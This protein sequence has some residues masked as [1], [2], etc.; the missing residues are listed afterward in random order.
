[1][2]SI[3]HTM[4]SR[5]S[6]FVAAMSDL[7][8]KSGATTAKVEQSLGTF[9][10]VTA[11][12]L[13]DLGD[14]AD[15]FTSHGR[16]LADAV[17]L[18]DSSNRRSDESLA[19]RHSGIETLVATLDARTE[20][21][22]ER[23]QRFSSLL[24][25]SL[26]TAATRAREI[27]GIVA[28]SSNES[29]QSI[30]QQYEL[31]RKASEEE[32]VRTGEALTAV[33]DEAFNEVQAMFTQSASRFAEIMQG[34]KQMATEMQRELETTRGELRRGILELP[35]ET[36]ESTAQMRRVI[37]D[38]IE[39]LA[40]LNRIVARHGRS[41]DASEPVRREAEPV[42]A[43][44]SGRGQVRPMRPDMAPPPQAPV[45]DITGAPTRR[46]SPP[47]L[48]PVPGGKDDN[49]PRNGGW[50]SDLLSRASREEASPPIAPTPREAP[51]EEERANRD[52]VDSI[53]S[54]SVDIARMID[55]DA[56]VEAWERYRRGERGVFT[57]RLYT[58]Q[59]QKAF[60]EIRN[61]YRS[62]PEFR[63]TVEH[64]IHEFERLLD[65]VARGD[66][67]P[68]VARNYLTSDTGKV[69]TMLAHA[70]GRF[71]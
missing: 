20:D 48:S 27:A 49:A 63:Q 35:Q 47:N 31:V 64:Y 54:L 52:N 6:E 69:F 55:N 32:R 68:A 37:V 4:A 59:G 25:E 71:E 66:R 16:T 30:E 33:Y 13:H 22:G 70:A 38:Q 50:L 1:M 8:S 65:D 45:R 61:K 28:E 12:V 29:V 44:G 9:N 53:D 15:Q 18:L 39:A 2:N 36:A 56:A 23:L 24:D 7:S 21:F 42:Y 67:G 19:A 11:R 62:D 41:L 46:S 34:M 51:R 60:D 3:E 43:A 57:R 40:E 58:Q 26:D 10:N 5:V 14:L 17:D